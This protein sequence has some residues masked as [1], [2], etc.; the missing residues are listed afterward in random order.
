MT[1]AKSGGSSRVGSRSG[2]GSS[3]AS[4]AA[5]TGLGGTWSGGRGAREATT[6]YPPAASTTRT[7]QPIRSRSGTRRTGALDP[8]AV[9]PHPAG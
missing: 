5:E 6:A 7:S 9:P 1:S 2:R 4:T 8:T 3:S